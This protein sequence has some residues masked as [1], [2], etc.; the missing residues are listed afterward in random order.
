MPHRSTWRPARAR[1]RRLLQFPTEHVAFARCVAEFIG[2]VRQHGSKHPWI[3]GRGRVIVGVDWILTL[4][5]L[6]KL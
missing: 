2:E 5:T 3:D 4:H 1:D 6:L